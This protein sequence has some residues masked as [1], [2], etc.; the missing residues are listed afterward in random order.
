M[1]ESTCTTEALPDSSRLGRRTSLLRRIFSYPAALAAGLVTVTVL[2]AVGRLDDPDVWWHLRVGE[3]IWKTHVLPSSDL[4]SF[5]AKDHSWIAHEWLSEVTLYAAYRVGGYRGLVLWACIAG[6]LIYLIVY[7]LCWRMT[8]N[9]LVSL[10]GGMIAFC[11]GSVG[12][13]TRPL[14]L[15]HLCLAAEILILELARTRHVRWLWLLPPIFT[16]WVNCHG[17]Y[18]VGIAVLALYFGCSFLKGHY[19]LFVSEE[20]DPRLRRTLAGMLALCT[21]AVFVNPIGF[22]LVLYPFDVLFR[23]KTNVGAIEEWFPPSLSEAN[24][25]VL[26][27]AMG[28]ILVLIM[29]RRLSIREVALAC[30]ASG[31][32]LQH[33]RMVFLFGIITAPILSHYGWGRAGKR[34]HPLANAAII[35]CCLIV[36]IWAFP[37][38]TALE[39]QIQRASPVKA[40]QYI[41]QAH[42][43]GPMLNEFQFGGYLI[44]RMPETKVFIDGRTDLFDW[45]GVMSEYLRWASLQED[46]AL[47]LNKYHIKFCLLYRHAPLA[48]VIPYLPGWKEVYADDLAVIFAR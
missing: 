32:A 46:P 17:S 16:V 23:Q 9:A 44:W 47:L 27:A 35:S 15:G 19:S 20:W 31:M 2:T 26:L 8:K 37:D 30:M 48:R 24:T 11:F 36:L 6:A 29:L 5:T 13:S 40:V 21:A 25:F 39:A 1:T 10:R 14:L 7:L 3:I 22:R 33:R 41:R 28:G 12:L 38:N 42:L 34:E 45:T 18:V 4:F 43:S